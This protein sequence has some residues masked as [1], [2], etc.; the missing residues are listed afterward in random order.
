MCVSIQIVQYSYYPKK[1]NVINWGWFSLNCAIVAAVVAISLIIMKTPSSFF[2]MGI[3][4]VIISFVKYIPQVYL[5]FSRKSTYGWSIENILLDFTGGSLSFI[6]I[7]VDWADSGNTS[8]FSGGLNVAKFLLGIISMFYDIIFMMQHYVCYRDHK[9]KRDH[10]RKTRSFID[11]QFDGNMSMY[12]PEDQL[13]GQ[14]AVGQ[15]VHHRNDEKKRTRSD[16]NLNTEKVK[17]TS[18][19]DSNN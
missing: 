10:R 9:S 2:W 18:R 3:G 5:N 4:K 13:L 7:F 16:V 12:E 8:Q 19:E 14:N 11:T 17:S 1:K 15:N 6:Q